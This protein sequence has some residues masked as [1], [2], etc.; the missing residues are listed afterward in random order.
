MTPAEARRQQR[1]ALTLYRLPA[2]FGRLEARRARALDALA[3]ALADADAANVP[4]FRIRRTPDG[5]VVEPTEPVPVDQLPAWSE[6]AL[7]A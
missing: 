2:V 6:E 3:A 5:I 7:T 4:G 1:A